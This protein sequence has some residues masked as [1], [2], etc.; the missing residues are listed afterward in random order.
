M[1]AGMALTG[2][3]LSTAALLA[4]LGAPDAPRA[5]VAAEAW[6][7]T[8]DFTRILVGTWQ[9][10]LRDLL[11]T[12]DVTLRLDEDGTYTTRHVLIGGYTIFMRGRWTA[13][14][15][16]ANGAAVSNTGMISFE[17][18]ESQPEEFCSS[19]IESNPLTIR[20]A[21]TIELGDG[22]ANYASGLMRRRR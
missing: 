8:A 13:Q 18:T 2:I 3:G 16:T 1:R 20:D 17:V 22:S 4:A 6:A 19:A 21:D 5:Q 9:G 11:G 15:V 14:F 12:F 10:D 7:A